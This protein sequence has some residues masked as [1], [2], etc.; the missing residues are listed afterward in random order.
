VRSLIWKLGGALL[1]VVAVS[2]GL[3]AFLVSQSTTS[4]FRQYLSRCDAAYIQ[5]V[6]DNLLQLYARDKSWTGVQ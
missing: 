6:E 1:L 4:E 3:T 2:V 5:V